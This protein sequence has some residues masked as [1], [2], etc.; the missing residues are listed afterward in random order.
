[1]NIDTFDRV[2][3][4]SESGRIVT[5]HENAIRIPI[6]S[7][8]E[9]YATFLRAK[10]LSAY[11]VV[12]REVVTDPVSYAAVFGGALAV[13]DA[14]EA[15]NPHLMKFQADLVG[16]ALDR[17]R[18]A[19][20]ADCGLGKTPMALAWAHAVAEQGKVLVLVPLAVFNQ[21]KREC[22]RFHGTTMVDLRAGETWTEG[23]AIANYE[24]RRDIDMTGVRGIVLDESSIL[25]NE[26]GDTRDWLCALAA[27]VPYRLAVSATPAPND[28]AE[29]ASHAVFLGYATTAKEFFSRF[30]RKDG[31]NWILRGHAIVPFYRNLSTWS[32]YVYSPKALGYADSTEMGQE[33]QYLY[34]PCAVPPGFVS[35]ASGQLFASVGT[36]EDRSAVFGTLRATPGPRADAILSYLDG[37]RGVVWCARNA[38]E[39]FVATRLR[40]TGATVAVINGTMEIEERVELV[41]AYRSGHVDHI[42]SKA[43]VLGFGVNLPECDHMV[44]SGFGFSFEETYQAIRRAHRYG[45]KGRLE[46]M[47]PYTDPEAP[48]LAVLREKQARFLN[49]VAEMQRRFWSEVTP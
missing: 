4:R 22:L 31:T 34:H 3:D 39:E 15:Q 11:R 29:Y 44:Y 26:N 8:P 45:R 42:V 43:R 2:V 10:K 12:G 5:F 48:A 47:F 33:P 38:E 40:S 13:V 21:W 32:T 28:H 36:A 18:F 30:F 7:T 37:K 17:Q 6:P 19:I 14:T 24:A 23:I 16:R 41:D 9:G 1:M 25:K 46:V 20:F 35:K 27:G 49:D